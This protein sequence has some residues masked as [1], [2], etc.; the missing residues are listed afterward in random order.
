MSKRSSLW[1]L[2]RT[3][4]IREKSIVQRHSGNLFIAR[5]NVDFLLVKWWFYSTSII[6][7]IFTFTS[8]SLLQN[9]FSR[10]ETTINVNFLRRGKSYAIDW[11]KSDKDKLNINFMYDAPIQLAA[12]IGAINSSK[13]YPFVVIRYNLSIAIS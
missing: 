1:F 8:T 9:L 2:I 13:R 12:Y 11:K 3:Y 10:K 6:F 5:A 7:Y 4:V